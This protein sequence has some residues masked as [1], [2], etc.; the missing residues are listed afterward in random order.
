MTQVSTLQ[1]T[2]E[3]ALTECGINLFSVTI[4]E[5]KTEFEVEFDD[6]CSLLDGETLSKLHQKFKGDF[7]VR[8]VQRYVGHCGNCQEAE[9]RLQLDIRKDAVA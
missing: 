4:T 2:L 8:A 7:E 3:T 6:D 5:T 9:A 1:Q